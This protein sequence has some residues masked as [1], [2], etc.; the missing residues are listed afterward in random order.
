[1][2]R[3]GRRLAGTAVAASTIAISGGA[4]RASSKASVDAARSIAPKQPSGAKRRASSSKLTSDA[5]RSSALRFR[6]IGGAVDAA[7]T[8]AVGTPIASSTRR[9]SAAGSACM[10][11]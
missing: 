9:S 7:E 2:P 1:M 11:S 5:A 8:A 3:R 4:Q 6:S 10:R